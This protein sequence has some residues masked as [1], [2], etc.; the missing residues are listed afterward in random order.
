MQMS[1]RTRNLERVKRSQSGKKRAKLLFASFFTIALFA[2]I[3]LISSVTASKNSDTQSILVPDHLS[4][5]R[6][7]QLEAISIE[8]RNLLIGMD[9]QE[10]P[11]LA[12]GEM[13]KRL[14]EIIQRVKVETE[15]NYHRF[16][17][18]PSQYENSESFYKMLMLVT[19]LQ[20]DYGMLYN[21]ERVTQAGVIEPNASFY[22]N[23]HDVFLH[24]L[25]QRQHSG[26]C[27]SLPVLVIAVGRRLGYPLALVSTQN[28]LFVRWNGLDEQFNIEAT[29]KGM[30]THSDDYYRKWPYSITFQTEKD[31]GYLPPMTAAEETAVFFSLRAFCLMAK[32]Q[33][34]E[35]LNAHKQAVKLAPKTLLYQKIL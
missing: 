22:A 11:R 33:V 34:T 2:L 32:G 29:S 15:R 18:N 8:E 30:N 14:D 31:N 7:D 1:M 10:E 4:E 3:A 12:M 20:Q 13:L 23:S 6:N 28:H 19:V 24:G 27:A 35:S 9:L 21:P 16:L 17:A 25:L 5:M 26:T